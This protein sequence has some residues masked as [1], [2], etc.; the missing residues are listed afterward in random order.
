MNRRARVLIVGAGPG[1][2]ACAISLK[3]AGI[4]VILCDAGYASALLTETLHPGIE[5]LMRMLGMEDQ[6]NMA[7]FPRHRGYFIA[8]ARNESF[9]PYGPDWFGYQSDRTELRRLFMERARDIGIGLLAPVRAYGLLFEAESVRGI[10][11][12]AGEF[13]ADFVVDATGRSRALVRIAGGRVQQCSRTLIVSYGYRRIE[14]ASG[15]SH[16]FEVDR[17]TW[18][19]SAPMNTITLHWAQLL[20]KYESLSSESHTNGCTAVGREKLCAT[21]A[22]WRTVAE[23][24]AKGLFVVGDA[25]GNID[26][27]GGSGVIRAIVSGAMAAHM[28]R[29]ILD[30]RLSER[31]AAR[32][33]S[34]WFHSLFDSQ[35]RELSSRYQK[36]GIEVEYYKIM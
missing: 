9:F 23:P 5:P 20:R 33:Y 28:I 34:H 24:A 26:P 18:R 21:D 10:T 36:M 14:Y 19:W 1:G 3:Q 7:G 32:A 30:G 4:D 15:E 25:A 17:G 27:A 8:D 2:A 13:R 12:S 22:T 11:S 31:E 29:Q 6:F 35:C 16:R